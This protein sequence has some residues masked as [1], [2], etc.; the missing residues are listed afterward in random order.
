MEVLLRFKTPLQ[1]SAWSYHECHLGVTHAQLWYHVTEHKPLVYNQRLWPVYTAC[2]FPNSDIHE[3]VITQILEHGLRDKKAS[4][5]DISDPRLILSIF[6]HFFIKKFLS[7][8]PTPMDKN[9]I[10]SK[11]KALFAGVAIWALLATSPS[12]TLCF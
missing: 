6:S 9:F 5:R 8:L 7:A 3:A 4:A 11:F 1:S 12:S 2:L 10:F